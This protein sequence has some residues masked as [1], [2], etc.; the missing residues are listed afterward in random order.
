MRRMAETGGVRGRCKSK[1]AREMHIS[2]AR[3]YQF[4]AGRPFVAP[5]GCAQAGGWTHSLHG[6]LSDV[7]GGQGL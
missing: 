6:R 5:G 4:T 1:L 2:C 7:R 3:G